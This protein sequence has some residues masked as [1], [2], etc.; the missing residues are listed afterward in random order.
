ME[1]I[2]PICS[3]SIRASRLVRHVNSCLDNQSPDDEDGDTSTTSIEL[4]DT[5][6]RK[7]DMFSALGLRAGSAQTPVSN[8]KKRTRYEPS[9]QQSQQSSPRAVAGTDV[10]EEEAEKKNPAEA[11]T[12]L[13]EEII[14][15]AGEE[16]EKRKERQQQSTAAAATSPDSKET[17]EQIR[18]QSEAR[19]KQKH[20]AELRRRA[21]I[22][23]AHRLRP[24]TLDEFIG[25]EK[26]IGENAPL[27]NMIKADAVPSFLLWGPPG[28]GKT[29]MARIIAKSTNYKYAELSGADSNATSLKEAFT[30]AEN[31]KR[32]TGQRTLLFLDEIHRYNKAV[33]DLLLPVIEKG[34]CTVIGATTENPSFTLNNALLSR[35]HTFVM[36]PLST[37]SIVR[38]LT[39]ALFDVNQLRKHLF[40]LHYMTL[41]DQAFQHI[42]EL[43]MGD[44]RVAL[45]VLETVNAYLSTESFAPK[46]DK[47]EGKQG[48][49]K[50]TE[51]GLKQILQSRDFHSIY[52][53]KG[54]GHYDAISAFQKTIRGSD[55]DAAIFYLVKMLSG[56][57]DP[58]FI[59][60]RLIVIASEDIGLR[61]S[62]CLPFALAAKE[63]LE[64]LGMPEG[65]IVL[66]HC[67]NKLALAPK[68]TKS[69]RSLRAAQGLL[70]EK[71]DITRLPVPIHLR[72]A[73]TALMKEM[74]FGEKYKY[75]PNY[76]NG[77]IK[78][79][80]FP[81][82]MQ[83]VKLLEATHLGKMRDEEVSDEKYQQASAAVQDYESYK[84]R[85]KSHQRE[86]KARNSKIASAQDDLDLPSEPELHQE[87]FGV[88]TSSRD[89]EVF[90]DDPDSTNNFGKTYDEFLDRDS[91]PDYFDE[92]DDEEVREVEVG[93]IEDF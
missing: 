42:A 5:K 11:V 20:L 90:S 48:V 13:R 55:P 43:C 66:A 61:D 72:N 93:E 76:E 62:S 53:K 41:E 44:S 92:V 81:D 35:A 50:V 1:S 10:K 21:N 75:N 54:D 36:E 63:A 12:T 69:Y 52:D 91:Q 15:V 7:R 70:K 6:S 77:L 65:E 23:L 27:R 16:F 56:G 85:V 32:L 2:C 67:T 86:A 38:I 19:D 73:P 89:G 17:P 8:K 49:V 57:E 18:S 87:S 51:S 22:P 68:S 46:L 78:Q 82:G 40:N 39:R 14:A 28:C 26:L 3:R 30:Q 79:N 31:L 24:K 33:Q 80:Y 88:T 71:P 64:F 84:L 74:G 45:N 47:N 37:A 58:L 59:M 83:P 25:Q 29:T 9:R 34:T 60:R 4:I